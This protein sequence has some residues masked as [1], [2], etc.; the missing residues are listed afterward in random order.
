MNELPEPPAARE[1]TGLQ[2]RLY[3]IIFRSDTFGGKLF[4]AT[5]LVLIM[6]SI[7]V[8][9]ME[10]V[11][12]VK[13]QYSHQMHM[14]EWTFTVLFSAEYLLRIYCSPSR[15]KYIGSFFGIIDL[16]SILPTYLSLFYAGSQYLMVVRSFRLLRAARIFKL[17][18][19]ISEGRMLR[20]ALKA[21]LTKILVFLST[22]LTLIVIIGSLMYLIE[23]PAHG[24]S[25][26]PKSIYWTIVTLTTVGY[27]DIAP[28]TPLGQTL[29]SLVM[30]LGYGII[31]VPTGIVTVE[32]SK[33][34][35][36][37][38]IEV[39]P[40]PNCQKELH[41]PGARFCSR[42]GNKLPA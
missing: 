10:T 31:A 7:L 4:D 38:A 5:L 1:L 19:F 9:C 26:I 15:K 11:P 18:R 23:G 41:E 17:N 20:S 27:G 35:Q 29:A 22:I 36:A 39:K 32:L 14:A 6:L 42:C 2:R 12:E 30:I 40:C 25:S 37:A 33:A 8:V 3:Q 16:L 13:R 28:Q 24:F 34:G 21:S